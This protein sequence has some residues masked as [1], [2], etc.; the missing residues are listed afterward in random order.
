MMTLLDPSRVIGKGF[1]STVSEAAL[2]HIF[3]WS[4]LLLGVY[5]V[6]SAPTARTMAP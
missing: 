6:F 4:S 5:I 1:R 2:R 3:F